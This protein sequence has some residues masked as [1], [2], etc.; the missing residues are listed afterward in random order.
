MM[1]DFFILRLNEFTIFVICVFNTVHISIENIYR[2]TNLE[3]NS[4][5]FWRIYHQRNDHT[6]SFLRRVSSRLSLSPKEFTL[7][8][9]P[10]LL[11]NSYSKSLYI[12]GLWMKVFA[13]LIHPCFKL[14][15]HQWHLACSI[16]YKIIFLLFSLLLRISNTWRHP[17]GCFISQ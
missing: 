13:L 11:P 16:V 17:L 3:N 5:K 2:E 15:V 4:S 9:A 12:A 8:S 7:L 10:K 6:F 1:Y 14:S